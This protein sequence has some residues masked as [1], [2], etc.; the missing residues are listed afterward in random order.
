MFA[1][2]AFFYF[3]WEVHLE[4]NTLRWLIR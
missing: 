4:V 3:A 1:L 2:Q